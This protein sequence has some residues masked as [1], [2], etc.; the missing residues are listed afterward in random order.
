VDA[1]EGRRRK[2]FILI[3][4]FSIPVLL[5]AG[6]LIGYLL[7]AGHHPQHHVRRASPPLWS[8]IVGV[9]LVIGGVVVTFRGLLIQRRS[10]N[11]L[12]PWLRSPLLPL[13]RAERRR[14][15][16]QVRANRAVDADRLPVFRAAAV[17]MSRQR[18]LGPIYLGGSLLFAGL[19]TADPSWL[20]VGVA[21]LY[22]VGAI[23]S[24]RY[25]E[26]DA[27][28]AERFLAQHPA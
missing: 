10:G 20:R 16:K 6:G 11:G 7:A 13:P 1:E 14:V 22:A 3:L 26:Y 27:R 8:E 19:A 17:L 2:R 24:W 21:V 25:V 5:A 12:L 18:H 9:L 23:F 28:R 15:M 4:L